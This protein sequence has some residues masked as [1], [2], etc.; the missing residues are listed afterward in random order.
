MTHPTQQP[1]R[2]ITPGTERTPL[3]W[4]L[5]EADLAQVVGGTDPPSGPG[6]NTGR[7]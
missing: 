1:D 7:Q 4:A 2:A 6:D 3:I 5:T